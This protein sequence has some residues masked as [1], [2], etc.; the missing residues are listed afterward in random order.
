MSVEIGL[1][2]EY[3]GIVPEV[4]LKKANGVASPEEEKAWVFIDNLVS[5]EHISEIDIVEQSF[6]CR[7]YGHCDIDPHIGVFAEEIS[8]VTLHELL[9]LYGCSEAQIKT[10][11]FRLHPFWICGIE[12]CGLG[13]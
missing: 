1:T 3:Y 11:D 4:H 5:L 2:K 6:R 8:Q 9:H 10:I 7:A 12:A 13:E